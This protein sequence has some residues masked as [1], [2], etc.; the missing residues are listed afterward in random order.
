[1]IHLFFARRAGARVAIYKNVVLVS[2]PTYLMQ[3]FNLVYF[4][5][6]RGNHHIT[7]HF[8]K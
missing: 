7:K 2:T 1:M 4:A 5:F 8:S 3:L 6:S